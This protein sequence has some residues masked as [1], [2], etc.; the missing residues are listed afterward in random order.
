MGVGYEEPLS[1]FFAGNW[2]SFDRSQGRASL[3]LQIPKK[4]ISCKPTVNKNW[5]PMKIWFTKMS[6]AGND[7]V[8]VDNRSKKIRNG[9]RAARILCD[10]RW[11][12]GADGLLLLEKSRKADY[13]MLY[14]NADGSYGG[15]C[16]NGGRCIARYAAVNG[17][18][19]LRHR[20]EA[21]DHIYAASVRGSEVSLTMKDP[22]GF[23]L[24]RRIRLRGKTIVISHV[25]TGSPHVV[26][27]CDALGRRKSLKTIDVVA[28][29]REIRFHSVFSPA[30]TNV[31]FIERAK[32]NSIRIRTY[33]R[34]V[35]AET[36]A[37]GTG[38]I[39]SAIV[40]SRLWKL[41][42]P[43]VV[44]PESGRKLCVEFDDDGTKISKVCLAGP[45]VMSF[46]GVFSI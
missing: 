16:G 46:Y 19:P 15:M 14:F 1:K 2:R 43:I 36:L 22:R 45:A 6:G 34:G 9:P 25:D 41:K 33:E 42:A 17:I 23:K 20:F 13:R 38:S 30:G 11:G 28:L 37:C 29:G 10:R 32:G 7:F 39:A 35:E 18:A 8:I 44:I 24:R 3:A 26:V 4:P 12:V 5:D 31:N 40:A 21:L 27:P